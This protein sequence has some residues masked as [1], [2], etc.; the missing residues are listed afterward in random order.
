MKTAISNSFSKQATCPSSETLLAYGA[1]ALARAR[2]EQVAEHL[3]G[4][5]FCDAELRFL[6]EHFPAGLAECPET[7][8]PRDLRCLAEALL[9][10]TLKTMDNLIGTTYEKE[11]LTLTDA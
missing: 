2:S 8:I 4:C 9:G 1:S 3:C 10:G 11:G 7:S 6:K 5:E